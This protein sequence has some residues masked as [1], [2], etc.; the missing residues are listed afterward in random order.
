LVFAKIKKLIEAGLDL[1]IDRMPE[2]S[3]AV[4]E[5]VSN[6][7]PAWSVVKLYSVSLQSISVETEKKSVI[8]NVYTVAET[9]S[10]RTIGSFDRTAICSLPHTL[11]STLKVSETPPSKSNFEELVPFK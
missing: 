7:V 1:S 10:D 11:R 3:V 8:E 2:L 6:R 9:D 5:F 4:A